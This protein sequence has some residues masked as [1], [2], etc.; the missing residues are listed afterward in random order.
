MRNRSSLTR[1]LT[2]TAAALLALS[3]WPA[4]ATD[5]YFLHGVGAKAKG[6]AGVA[7]AMPQDA[8]AIAT[9]PASATRLDH[10]IDIGVDLFIPDRSARIAGNVFGL[11]GA[12]DGN[13]ANPFVLGDIAYVRPLSDAVSV[14]LAVYANGG[15]NTVYES[16]PLA[17]FG[18]TGKA[19]VDL[20]Q[21][22]VVPTLA[23]EFA[24]GQSLGVSAVGLV[25]SFRA[26][27]IQPLAT[28]SQDPA[29]FGDRGTDWSL[30]A[31][32]KVGYLGTFG[33]RLSLGAFYQSKIK[34]QKFDKYAGLFA[35][36]GSFDVPANWGVGMSAR[37]ADTLAI[38]ADF[39]R[40]EYAGVN[41][42][43]NPFARLGAGI[44]FGGTDGPGFGWRDISVV[45]VGAVWDISDAVTVRAGYGHAQNPVPQSETL[46]NILAP[47]VV[48]DH[49][50]AG[51]SVAL[52]ERTD[53]TLHGLVAPRNQV[54][55][56]G[57]ID[58]SIGGGEA[59]IA[60]SEVSFGVGLGF[61]F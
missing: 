8:A 34:A 23:Y 39:K 50:T 59:D 12:Y 11:D 45:K 7:I 29:S 21:G 36:G 30:G 32:V 24:A 3:A 48:S 47:G 35:D 16:N 43:G 56:Q 60:L 28:L 44:P 51:A 17:A 37:V 31:G 61:V 41:A 54:R 9:N 40:I 52:G 33:D 49:F 14:G 53:L 15:M 42:V 20:K 25:Q 13:G 57:S 4:Q 19:G 2:R 27:G 22:F 46:L 1:G 58:P 38:G 26:H 10:R 5:G 6:V 55:G 18:A